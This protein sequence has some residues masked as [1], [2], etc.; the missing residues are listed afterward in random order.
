[1]NKLRAKVVIS[2]FH[3]KITAKLPAKSLRREF[4]A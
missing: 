4:L 1:M 2:L 3:T